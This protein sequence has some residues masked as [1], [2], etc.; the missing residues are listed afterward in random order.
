MLK[1]LPDG[2][3]GQKVE[4][5]EDRFHSTIF[6][7]DIDL[8]VCN[9]KSVNY[10]L[11][12]VDYFNSLSAEIM[13]YCIQGSIR[14]CNSF[15]DEI[16]DPEICASRVQWHLSD[17][18]PLLFTVPETEG[19]QKPL[20]NLLLESEDGY[21]IQWIIKD[22]QIVYIGAPVYDDPFVE[23]ASGDSNYAALVREIKEFTPSEYFE[24]ITFLGPP[25]HG[26]LNDKLTI[27]YDLLKSIL[28]DCEN[29]FSHEKPSY[30][31]SWT[32][33]YQENS[34]YIK[35]S[36][37]DSLTFVRIFKKLQEEYCSYPNKYN[38]ATQRAECLESIVYFLQERLNDDK[39][40]WIF[41]D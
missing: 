29:L 22:D 35:L 21:E 31:S 26:F 2:E 1:E 39:K 5:M 33:L 6:A 32:A 4:S 30:V 9:P 38:D 20:V 23:I 18:T 15:E 17:L 41:S 28:V 25:Q 34:D 12:C 11:E 19:S 16:I 36:N 10:A 40:I 13:Y 24:T 3:P 7:T 27:R 14:F 8:K 37:D